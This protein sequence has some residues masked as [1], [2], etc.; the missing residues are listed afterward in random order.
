MPRHD[1]LLIIIHQGINAC[2]EPRSLLEILVVRLFSLSDF[3]TF[4]QDF[5]SGSML[6]STDFQLI[7]SIWSCGFS[8][9]GLMK[10]PSARLLAQD[11]D[12]SL[13][14]ALVVP[15]H[16]TLDHFRPSDFD[17]GTG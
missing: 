12:D 11:T 14:E 2:P 8:M 6:T 5:S 17:S 16:T 13:V 15:G 1:K 4:T 3:A 10:K 9:S 7:N